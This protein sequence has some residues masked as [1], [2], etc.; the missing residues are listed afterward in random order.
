MWIC[1]FSGIYAQSSRINLKGVIYDNKT[2]ERIPYVHI[3]ETGHHKGT[4]ADNNGNFSISADLNDTLKFTAIGY[5]DYKLFISDSLRNGSYLVVRLNSRTYLLDNLNFYAND[6]MHGFYLKDIKRDT[7]HIAGAKGYSSAALSGTPAAGGYIT[8]FANLFNSHHRQEK[9]L[10]G[11]LVTEELTR[12]EQQEK[13][14]Q[15]ELI[16]EKY[17]IELVKRI[18]DL[19]GKKLEDFIE[20]YKPS[21]RFIL[22]ATKYEIALQIVNSYRDYRFE[23]G[24]EVDMNEILRRAKFKN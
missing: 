15:D 19:Q 7:I 20:K 24:L 22:R 23:N 4:A 12:Q 14:K 21:N 1:G 9:K 8:D 10:A 17:S 3:I 11:I 2:S 13:K 18:T 16:N 5:E 6:P